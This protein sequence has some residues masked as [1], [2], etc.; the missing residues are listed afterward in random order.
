VADA[1]LLEHGCALVDIL[2]Q[3]YPADAAISAAVVI[4]V[5]TIMF[6]LAF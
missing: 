2:C 5:L 3:R 1:A 6:P 4:S